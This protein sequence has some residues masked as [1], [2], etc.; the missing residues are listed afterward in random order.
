MVVSGLLVG[1]GGSLAVVVC[2]VVGI[3]CS[4]DVDHISNAVANYLDHRIVAVGILV[5]GV[6]SVIDLLVELLSGLSAHGH[7]SLSVIIIAQAMCKLLYNGYAM[8]YLR[9]GAMI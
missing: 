5:A 3:L 7:P 9:K 4:V 8:I 6:A 2:V 1:S